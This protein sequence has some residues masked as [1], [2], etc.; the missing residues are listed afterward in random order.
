MGS[1]LGSI[2]G[3]IF[4]LKWGSIFGS[5]FGSMFDSKLGSLLGTILGSIFGSIFLFNIV[6]IFG[7]ILGLI[8]LF[9][10]HQ[11][12]IYGIKSESLAVIWSQSNNFV[13]FEAK[14]HIKKLILQKLFG[15]VCYLKIWHKK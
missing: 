14:H 9:N 5:M 2:L 7:S 10:P 1:M 12:V 15:L 6:S 8:L 13:T 4:G 3:K 11:T